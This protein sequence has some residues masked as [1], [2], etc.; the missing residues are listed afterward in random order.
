MCRWTI[1][2]ILGKLLGCAWVEGLGEKGMG[3]FTSFF[4]NYGYYKMIFRKLN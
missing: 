4:L 3:E 2:F 1:L